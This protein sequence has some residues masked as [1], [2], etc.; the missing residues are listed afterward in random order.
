MNLNAPG[1]LFLVILL[2]NC[3]TDKVNTDVRLRQSDTSTYFINIGDK[4][5]D[6]A[7]LFSAYK[8][9]GGEICRRTD[10]MFNCTNIFAKI[11]GSVNTRLPGEYILT[12][13][14]NDPDGHPLPTVTRTVHVIENSAGF[15]SGAYTVACTCSAA[16]IGSSNFSVSTENYS[17]TIN[18]GTENW[19]FILNSLK[20]GPE[21]VIP[22]ANLSGNT[23]YA[24]YF[25]PEYNR[26]SITGTLSSSKS[27]FTLQSIVDS[28][29]PK[30]TYRCKS[31]YTEQLII[32]DKK[33]NN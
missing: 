24:G 29:Y 6:T 20:I 15:L 32:E 4:K 3:D 10:C 13:M 31:V 8:I 5:I 23:I 7:Y 21:Y 27:S 22:S 2:Q 25:G 26:V 11:I 9:P 16:P 33:S 30:I 17:A 18:P 12:Y 14:A 19:H 1:L 28:Y